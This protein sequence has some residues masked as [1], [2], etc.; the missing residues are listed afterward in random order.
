MNNPAA[1]FDEVFP[2]SPV[3]PEDP[4][5]PVAVPEPLEADLL[6]T[7]EPVEPVE[8]VEPV[9]PAPPT[10]PEAARPAP[11]ATPPDALDEVKLPPYAKPNTAKAFDEV[12]SAARKTIAER[13]AR[14]KELET[15]GTSPITEDR[16]P[17]PL[18]AELADLRKFRAAHALEGDPFFEERFTA[19]VQAIDEAIYNKFRD[20]GVPER[21]IES[22]KSFGGPDETDLDDLYSKLMA[23]GKDVQS[24]RRGVEAKLTQREELVEKRKD[25]LAEAHANLGKFAEDRK[26]EAGRAEEERRNQT[27]TTVNFLLEKTPLFQPRGTP[28]GTPPA[29]RAANETRNA[30]IGTLRNEVAALAAAYTPDNYAQAVAGLAL[31]KVFRADLIAEQGLAKAHKT[32]LDAANTRL[33]KLEASG[34]A[35]KPGEAV[36]ARVSPE[37][38][39]ALFNTTAD[40]AFDAFEKSQ[41][42]RQ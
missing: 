24:L 34:R 7:I 39:G 20:A 5:T 19:P 10:S 18:A 37:K 25:T 29:E 28:A 13:E 22:I 4:V 35:V 2:A 17:A 36:T 32:A 11:S 27:L 41:R 12:K 8:S 14:I 23:A 16:L 3:E 1:S 30:F 6:P 42:E 15:G 9:D 31:A 38:P 26:Q 40:E 21:T 33:A